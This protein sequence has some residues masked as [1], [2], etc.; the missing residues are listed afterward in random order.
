MP[1]SSR[2]VL[3]LPDLRGVLVTTTSPAAVEALD[4]AVHSVVHHRADTAANVACALAIDPELSVAHCIRGFG[5]KLLGRADLGP[6]AVTAAGRARSSLTSRGG[7]PREE[8]LVRGLELWCARDPEAA[9]RALDAA[10]EAAPLDL[11]SMKLAH[12]LS[13]LLG[14][15]KS[16]LESLERVVP[17]WEESGAD[18]L[19]SV[20]GCHA[21]TTHELGDA[22]RAETIGRRAVAIDPTDP[23]AV[24]AVAHTLHSRGLSEEGLAWLEEQT[25]CL[26]GANN[27]GGHVHWHRALCLLALGRDDEAL[28]LHDARVVEHPPGDYRDLVNSATLLFRLE[29]A[30][31]GVGDRWQRLANVAESRLGD[32]ASAFADT[33]HVFV[34]AQAGRQAEAERFVA[35]MRERASSVGGM[36]AATS[37]EVGVPVARAIVSLRADP[38]LSCDLLVEHAGDLGRLGG[39]HAQREIFGLIL[40]DARA[41]RLRRAASA[42]A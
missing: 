19:G 30:G 11:L 6:V 42:A 23:W 25:R 7:T 12:A 36:E 34:L 27:F 26:D 41:R 28:E 29:Q 38:A 5:A 22:A 24:H 15:T 39:S 8:L 18:G 9:I 31:V 2:N 32:H 35:S 20:L 17:A 33:H 16:M 4:A 21:F 40:D 10:Q 13:F 14:R 37:L 3:R 1:S